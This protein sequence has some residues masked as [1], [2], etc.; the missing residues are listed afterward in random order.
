[1]T[2][3]SHKT[4]PRSFGVRNIAFRMVRHSSWLPEGNAQHLRRAVIKDAHQFTYETAV[5]IGL[6]PSIRLRR[7]RPF[8]RLRR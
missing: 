3:I 4:H 6:S 2:L 1:M 5:L 8:R 7:F